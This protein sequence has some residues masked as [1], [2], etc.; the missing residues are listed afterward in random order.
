[1]TGSP[2]NRRWTAFTLLVY[3]GCVLLGLCIPW[4][5]T[6][7]VDMLKHDQSLAQALHQLRLHLFAPGYNLFL[8]GLLNAAPFLLF[9][10]FALLHMGFAPLENRRLR[11]RRSAGILVTAVGLIGLSSWTHLMT[12]WHPD[13]QGALAYLFL[14]FVLLGIMPISYALGRGMGTLIFR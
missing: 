4:L 14:P 5:A 12:L 10:I 7:T 3:W 9:A 8:I 6:I 13:A 1:M 2:L 11:G